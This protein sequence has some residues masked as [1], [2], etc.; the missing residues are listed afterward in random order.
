M[1]RTAVAVVTLLLFAGAAFANPPAATPAPT[2][3]VKPAAAPAQPTAVPAPVAKPA[4]APT[5]HT[6][7]GTISAVDQTA[8]T[9]TLKTT[10]HSYVFSTTDKTEYHQGKTAASWNDLKAGAKATVKYDK[11]GDKRTAHAIDLM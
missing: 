3:A 5:L 8:K 1:R 9:V 6:Q 11:T 10:S 2:A 4:P 7:I